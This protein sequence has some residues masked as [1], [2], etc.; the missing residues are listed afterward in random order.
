MAVANDPAGPFTVIGQSR[1]ADTFDLA[2]SGLASARYVRVSSTASVDDI[3][4]GGGSPTWPGAEIDAVGAFYPGA[5]T[6]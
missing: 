2:G 3:L 5:V 1:G 4:T 6:P